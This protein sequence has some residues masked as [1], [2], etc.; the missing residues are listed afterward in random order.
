[1][2]VPQRFVGAWEREHLEID[3]REALG[4]GRA[5]WIESGGTYVDVRAPGTIASGTSFGGRSAWR[6]PHLTWHHDLD[7]HPVPGAVDR[8]ELTL[9]D[10]RIIERGTGID[11]GTAAYEER[12]RRLPTTT[13]GVTIATHEHGIAVRVGDYAG[14]L[15]ALPDHSP[16]A[17]AWRLSG[18][19]W[20]D[21]ISF[22]PPADHP[23]P[24]ASGWRVTTGWRVR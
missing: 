22:G 4:I 15:L 17:R 10:D 1:M 3:G 2:S 11:G 24:D 6:P 18:G 16:S 12:W 19:R 13:L 21:L 9:A 14:L 23:E 8:G 7:A 5:L 20:L